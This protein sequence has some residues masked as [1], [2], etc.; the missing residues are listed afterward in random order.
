MRPE[1]QVLSLTKHYLAQIQD[2]WPVKLAVAGVS[3]GVEYVLPTD[4]LKAL[5][6]GLLVLIVADWLTGLL[7]SVKERV[8]ITS[9]RMR[10]GVIKHVGYALLVIASSAM[11][12][13]LDTYLNGVQFTPAILAAMLAY[14]CATEFKSVV[15]NAGRM[16]VRVPKWAKKAARSLAK[17]FGDDGPSLS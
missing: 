4:A 9:S 15:E 10:E 6:T 11:S 2:A 17:R 7:A 16:G 13:V 5:A 3:A 1:K 14:L 8:P 12:R